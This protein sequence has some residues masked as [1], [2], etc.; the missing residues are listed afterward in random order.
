MVVFKLKIYTDS[1]KTAEK[2]VAHPGDLICVEGIDYSTAVNDEK[3][4]WNWTEDDEPKASTKWFTVYSLRMF[5]DLDFDGDV[6]AA[7][8]AAITNLTEEC[9]WS[10]PVAS[11]ILR[12]VELMNDVH[13]PGNLVLSVSGTATV[14]VWT[15][16]SPTTN[17]VPVRN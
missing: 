9:G 5:G 8:H 4:I 14:Q 3:I 2:T 7:D 1:M 13:I 6:D 15:V 11:N 17:D 12:K 10:M 16:E